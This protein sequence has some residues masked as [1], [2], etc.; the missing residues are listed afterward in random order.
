VSV[1]QS[2][3]RSRRALAV[4]AGAVA[5]LSLAGTASAKESAGVI[6][7]APGVIPTTSCS[8]IQSLK[9]SGDPNDGESGLASITV[10][11]QVKPCDSKQVVTVETL[12]ADYYD[13]SAVLWDDPTAPLSGKFTVFGVTIAKNYRVTLVVRDAVTGATVGSVSRLANV[14]R[15]TGV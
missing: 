7:F 4:A 11:Y 12:V 5:V 13:A 10:D 6:T 1:H 14:P 8:P 9:I 3:Y 2:L 15:P